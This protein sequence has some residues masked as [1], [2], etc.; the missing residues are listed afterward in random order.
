MRRAI[1][2]TFDANAKS[3]AYVV[4]FRTEKDIGFP[5]LNAKFEARKRRDSKGAA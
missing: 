2:K 4:R 3:A 1:E 5:R